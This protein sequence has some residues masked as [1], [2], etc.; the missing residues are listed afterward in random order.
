M[1]ET[2]IAGFR[3]SLAFQERFGA[4]DATTDLLLTPKPGEGADA[5]HLS[6][7]QDQE[8]AVLR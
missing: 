4:P 5:A 6:G 3:A 8:T 1:K 7:C 2:G